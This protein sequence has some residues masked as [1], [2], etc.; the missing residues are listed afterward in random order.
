MIKKVKQDGGGF[1]QRALAPLARGGAGGGS[2]GAGGGAAP[3]WDGEAGK[4]VLR[5][6][7]LDPFV[8]VSETVGG[9]AKLERGSG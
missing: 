8:E 3:G 7:E 6:S 2:S 5:R 9:P 1:G 4:D